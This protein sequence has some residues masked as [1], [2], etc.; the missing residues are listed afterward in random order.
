[1]SSSSLNYTLSNRPGTKPNSPQFSAA[2]GLFSQADHMSKNKTM[3]SSPLPTPITTVITITAIAIATA[4][5]TATHAFPFAHTDNPL[6]LCA[7]WIAVFVIGLTCWMTCA[8]F[9]MINVYALIIFYD[10]SFLGSLIHKDDIR[11]MLSHAPLITAA[12]VLLVVELG[13]VYA[14]GRGLVWLAFLP[15]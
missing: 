5:S 8:F 2:N 7:S 6:L 9:M 10:S 12:A 3:I 14:L 1:M 13:G 11:K 4:T 15:W